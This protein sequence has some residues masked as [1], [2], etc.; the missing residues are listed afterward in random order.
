MTTKT[1]GNVHWWRRLPE[2]GSIASVVECERLMR[3]LDA[4]EKRRNELLN[5]LQQE[6]AKV[7]ERACALWSL[8]EMTEA[9][10]GWQEPVFWEAAMKL[11][12][13]IT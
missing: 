7:I 4:I 13:Q 6:N 5:E 1:N 10:S 12:T 2:A 3:E 9:V 8:D 11:E